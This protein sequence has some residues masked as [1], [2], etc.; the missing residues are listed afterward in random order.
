MQ[1]VGSDAVMLGMRMPAAASDGVA[2]TIISRTSLKSLEYSNETF[3]R[4]SHLRRPAHNR[5]SVRAGTGR[6][7]CGIDRAVQGRLVHHQ[8]DQERRLLGPQG[9]QGLVRCDCRGDAREELGSG[10]G[11][12]SRH[13]Q[14]HPCAYGQDSHSGAFGCPSRWRWSW[15]VWVNTSTKVYHCSGTK[16]YGKTKQGEYMTEAAAKAAGAH[17][18]HGKAC[19]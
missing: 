10:G 14:G 12:C 1:K 8:R 2:C 4:Q 13:V 19:S 5:R 11:A 16:Y 6:R 7:A 18:D 9:S 15:E 3:S 17:A